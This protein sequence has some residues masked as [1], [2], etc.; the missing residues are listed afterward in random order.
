ME[1]L[2]FALE[3]IISIGVMDSKHLSY[4]RDILL[5][6]RLDFHRATLNLK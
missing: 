5:K 2:F 4:S 6:N 3:E 1:N